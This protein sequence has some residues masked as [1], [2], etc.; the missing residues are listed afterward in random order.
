MT[1]N[2]SETSKILLAMVPLDTPSAPRQRE[3]FDTL[4]TLS[5]KRID[6][7]SVVAKEETL[8]FTLDGDRAAVALLPS[9]IPWPQIEGPCETAWWWPEAGAKLQGHTSHLIV[10][11][12]S[13]GESDVLQRAVTLTHLVAA[14]AAHV[15][16]AGVFWVGGGLVHDPRI[17]LEEAR[18][19]SL[20]NLPLHLW[21][22]FRIE[23][24]EEGTVRLFT[25]GMQ[26]LGRMEIEIPHSHRLPTEVLD[27]AYAIADYVLSR[28]AEIRDNH[29]IG[30]SDDEKVMARHAPSMFD[31][32]MTVVR[33][34]F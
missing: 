15:D 11:H 4:T 1:S 29:T 32:S 16:S 26:S 31:E 18:K 3:L 10:A 14:A 25:T 17:F 2:L 24:I 12:S 7:K 6:P 28:G 19:G 13:D 27:F 23:Q 20:D 5:G 9:P 30:R 34:E 8:A 33:L 21:V 22:D